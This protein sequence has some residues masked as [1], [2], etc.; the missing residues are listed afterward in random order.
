MKNTKIQDKILSELEEK[1][2]FKKAHQYSLEY[3]DTVLKR[4][5]YPTKEAID[6][7]TIF[8][9][10]LPDSPSEGEQVIDILHKFGSPATVTTLGGRYFGFVCG[11]ALPVS[12]AAKNLSTYWD[13]CPTM[14]V[15]SPIAGKLE[16]VVEKW[17]VNLFNLPIN[18][19]VGFVSG[20]T[21]ANLCALAA[22][23]YRILKRLN[24][25]INQK[26]LNGA[27][28]IRIIAGQAHSSVIKLFNY[29]VLEK[30]ISN[31][32]MLTIKEG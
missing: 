28:R 23:R 14:N 24:W 32:Q 6:R 20:T 30:I 22:A 1:L 15:L 29:L 11:S 18:T 12:L 16:A 9:E 21:I 31:G 17:M 19:S 7:L 4:N 10:D 27:P 26:G 2:V 13:Q 25:D 5:V 3:L 8:D